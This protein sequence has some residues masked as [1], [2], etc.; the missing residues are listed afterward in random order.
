[1]EWQVCYAQNNFEY[2]KVLLNWCQNFD[3]QFIYASSASVYGLASKGFVED[4][5]CE[6]PINMYAF[7][8]FQFDQYV[9]SV[10]A[11]LKSQT[12]GLRYFNVFGPRETHKGKMASTP[13]HFNN[14]L[15]ETG[16]LNLFEGS[17]GYEN[18]EQLRDFVYVKDCV[19]VNLW[20]L[21]N[22]QQSGIYN[23]GT[24][25]ARSFNHVANTVIEWHKNKGRHGQI[26]YI[27]FPEH[28][29]GSYQSYTKADITRL[30]S[31]GYKGIFHTL[32]AGIFD[33]LDT[34]NKS[35]E[36]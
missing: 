31:A 14:Q 34:I 36:P 29:K 2:S 20:F 33:Y 4:R 9:R 5:S 28:L 15:I 8:K 1:M 35:I 12:V 32:E 16:T 21:E 30:R 17:D 24:G 19:D 18:G 6:A 26:N 7:S 11:K 23:V 27:S 13:F 10:S 25:V 3:I 22:E